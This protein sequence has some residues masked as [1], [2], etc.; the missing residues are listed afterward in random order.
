MSMPYPCIT[1]GEL[2]KSLS[3]LDPD[4]PLALIEVSREWRMEGGPPATT[5]TMKTWGGLTLPAGRPQA[6]IEGTKT[7]L[8]AKQAR[9]ECTTTR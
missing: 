5:L 3:C 7:A 9:I 1:V 4:A 8:P 2:I 6:A